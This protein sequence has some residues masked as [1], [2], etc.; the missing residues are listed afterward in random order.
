MDQ[1]VPEP[2]PQTFDAWG[3][4]PKFVYGSS[5]PDCDKRI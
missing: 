5:A 1:I 4:S 3:R 2:V